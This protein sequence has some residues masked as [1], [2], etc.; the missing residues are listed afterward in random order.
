MVVLLL[1]E[2]DLWRPK[3]P[4]ADMAGKAPLLFD[5]FATLFGLLA[6]LVRQRL[7]QSSG[8]S[9]VAKLNLAKSIDKDVCWLQVSVDHIC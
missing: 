6:Y 8:E 5:F 3:P 7:W 1:D 2:D 4:G 9:E